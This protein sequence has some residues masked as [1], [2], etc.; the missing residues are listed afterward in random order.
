VPRK[1]LPFVPEMANLIPV[2][3]IVA[4]VFIALVAGLMVQTVRLKESAAK[5]QQL[6]RQIAA[7]QVAATAS[8]PSPVFTNSLPPREDSA[9]LL[10]LRNQA[11]QVIQLRAQVARLREENQQ[12]HAAPHGADAAAVV[13]RESWAFAGY[14]TPEAALQSLFFAMS[15]RDQKAFVEALSP[16]E[17]AR[18]AEKFQ[19]KTPEQI[20]ERWSRQTDKI[21]QITG[22]RILERD[23][24][25]P[26]EM[27]LVVYAGA[28]Q[29]LLAMQMKKAGEQWKF[30]GVATDRRQP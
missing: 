11:A 18:H 28:G 20:A 21:A 13:P 9:E 14:A 12:L 7:L 17:A 22:Y 3:A 24:L 15:Q 25:P 27:V 16:E 30:A 23:E 4:I 19:D 10:Q 29:G 6:E 26:D 8:E 5:N 1:V 2:R